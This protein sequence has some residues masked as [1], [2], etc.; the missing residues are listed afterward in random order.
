M[1]THTHAAK[2]QGASTL[3]PFLSSPQPPAPLPGPQD[4]SMVIL[5]ALAAKTADSSS[6]VDKSPGPP[7]P[8]PAKP[9]RPDDTN[10]DPSILLLALLGRSLSVPQ[11]LP[12]GLKS[13]PARPSVMTVETVASQPANRTSPPAAADGKAAKADLTNAQTQSSPSA[14]ADE[15]K[16]KADPINVQTQL[17]PPAAADEKIAKAD[18]ID[19]Q[20]QILPSSAVDEK[21]AQADPIKAQAQLLPPPAAD[22][23]MAKADPINAQSP[24]S[25]ASPAEKPSTPIAR[26]TLASAAEKSLAP[27]VKSTHLNANAGADDKKSE[28]LAMSDSVGGTPTAAVETTALPAKAAEGAGTPPVGM[29]VATNSQ[30]MNLSAERNEIAGRTEQKLPPGAVTAT[31]VTAVDAVGA[32]GQRKTKPRLEFAWHDTPAQMLTMIDPAGKAIQDAR[33]IEGTRAAGSGPMSRIEMFVTREAENLRSNG[34]GS[35]G[36]SLQLDAHTQLFLQLTNKD[37]QVQASLRCER[38]D[39]SPLDSQWAQ[40]GQALAR[41][42]VQ[43]MPAGGGVSLSFQQPSE[44]PPRQLP[45]TR[46]EEPARHPVVET[47][48]RNPKPQSRSRPRWESWA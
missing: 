47:K 25:V 43:L 17:L 10:P 1:T 27:I 4:F 3:L 36:V 5:E 38:G 14:A 44:H 34:A 15:K 32:T 31:A 48:T 6:P 46:E 24:K 30:R 2:A 7:L 21:T 35:L 42:N 12:D 16:A 28:S 26:S 45:Q 9:A 8:A 29:G 20:T 23:K 41:Q 22:K 18:P 11:L 13:V 37:G 33:E 39:F 40:L 19:P